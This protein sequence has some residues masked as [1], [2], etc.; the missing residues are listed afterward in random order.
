M[1][2]SFTDEQFLELYKPYAAGESTPQMA[3]RLGVSRDLL[4]R[5]WKRL[6]LPI[7]RTMGRPPIERFLEKVDKD[8]PLPDGEPT[9]GNCWLWT[10]AKSDDGYGWF[11]IKVERNVRNT[12]LAH[13][14]IYEKTKGHIAATTEIDHLCRVRNCVNPDHLE[15]VSHRANMLRGANAA[16]AHCPRGHTYSEGNTYRWGTHR[17]CRICALEQAKKR[18]WRHR[19]ASSTA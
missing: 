8:G 9:L 18:Y 3:K 2:R 1:K 13:R 19:N 15:A 4:R 5:G 10:A 11:R 17:R 12:V 6:G 16:K 7:R 14:W